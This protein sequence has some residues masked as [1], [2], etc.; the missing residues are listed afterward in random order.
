MCFL[1]K[2]NFYDDNLFY[3]IHILFLFKVLQFECKTF[4]NLSLNCQV[5]GFVATL[6]V[7]CDYL[8]EFFC[9]SGPRTEFERFFCRS[10]KNMFMF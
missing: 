3:A 2:K 4:Q 7:V 6:Q 9:A 5:S 1:I 8:T 10:I